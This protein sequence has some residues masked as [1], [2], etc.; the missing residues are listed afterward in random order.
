MKILITGAKGMLGQM[1]PEV[2]ASHELILTD[3]DEMDITSKSQVSEIFSREKP[4]LIVHCAAYID[5]EKAEDEPEIAD[6][7][8]RVGS[9]NI[10]VSAE[11]IGATVI[12]I[13]TD[14]VFDG[15][16]RTPYLETDPTHPLNVYGNSKL[17]GENEIIKGCSKYYI[18]RVAWLFGEH[19]PKNFVQKMLEIARSQG[20]LKVINDQIGSPT[21]TRDVANAVEKII[22]GVEKSKPIEYGIY[23]FSGEGATSR[24]EFT[25]EIL[26]LGHINATLEPVTAKEFL[27]KAERPQ[28]SYLDKSK[29]EKALHFK[30][31]SW[32]R[33][34][35]DYFTRA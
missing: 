28:Y 23:H 24:F 34:L 7:V 17:D 4:E 31:R 29:I 16:K 1:M 25:K 8:N 12:N 26:K 22:E 10:A 33:M 15:E 32:E 30:V 14:Y 35:E 5:V 13:S 21:Y 9:Q 6:M 11:N 19:S 27:T 18:L 3:R 2:L 20:T